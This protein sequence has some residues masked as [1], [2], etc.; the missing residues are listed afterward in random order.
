[1]PKVVSTDALTEDQVSTMND[2]NL[3]VIQQESLATMVNIQ[4]ERQVSL[5]KDVNKLKNKRDNSVNCGSNLRTNQITFMLFMIT[6]VFIL[7]FIPNNILLILYAF[8]PS[9]TKNLSP[10]EI[11]VYALFL[12]TYVINNMVNPFIYGFCD[13][14]FRSESAKC[15]ARNS[16]IWFIIKKNICFQIFFWKCGN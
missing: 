4:K 12:R 10:T 6:L 9:F 8:D 2:I 7:S 1:M 5:T 15:V 16:N 11:T 3:E 14:K 13:K